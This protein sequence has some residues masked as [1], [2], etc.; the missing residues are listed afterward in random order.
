[1][2][3]TAIRQCNLR[4]DG[5]LLATTATRIETAKALNISTRRQEGNT[6]KTDT[7]NT[8]QTKHG[9]YKNLMR[10]LTLNLN[11]ECRCYSCRAELF[12][13]HLDDTL[14]VGQCLGFRPKVLP[15]GLPLLKVEVTLAV[16]IETSVW[17]VERVVGGLIDAPA[18]NRQVGRVAM[19]KSVGLTISGDA[20]VAVEILI[21]KFAV[22]IRLATSR[23]SRTLRDARV[24]DEVVVAAFGMATVILATTPHQKI[25]RVV[26]I[27]RAIIMVDCP[28][29]IVTI[30]DEILLDIALCLHDGHALE[31]EFLII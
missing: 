21:R 30:D 9:T 27:L 29:T 18:L 17:R 22:V 8:E 12:P 3:S 28:H 1:M 5:H 7:N 14:L 24:S 4:G 11:Y 2:S 31:A 25:R 19:L 26:V 13:G 20:V 10:D 15:K 23:T 16:L 6:T